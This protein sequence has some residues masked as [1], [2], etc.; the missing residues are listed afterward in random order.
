MLTNLSQSLA[1]EVVVA[2]QALVLRK[3][4]CKT[5]IWTEAVKEFDDRVHVRKDCCKPS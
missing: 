2:R 4:R 3:L 5:S 1:H